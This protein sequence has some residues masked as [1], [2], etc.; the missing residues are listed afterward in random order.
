MAVEMHRASFQQCDVVVIIPLHNAA[1]WLDDCLE[2]VRQQNFSGS[3]Q[4]SIFDD[5]STDD[6]YDIAIHWKRLLD[7][8][9][10]DVLI[11]RSEKASPSGVGFS[12][13]R[14]IEQSYGEYLCFLDADD[15]MTP[16]RISKQYNVARH[17]PNAIVGSR[18]IRDPPGSTER[19]TNW[20]NNLISEQLYHQMYTSNGPTVIM[21]TWFCSRSV[22]DNVGGFAESGSGTPEDLIFF[23][24]HLSSGGQ[25][26]RVDDVLV[27]Y[28]Y[29]LTSVTFSISED[30][31]W[32]CRVGAI[33]DCV[34]NHWKQ[35]TIWNAGKQGKRFYRSLSETN[36]KK[37]QA[38]CDVDIRKIDKGV[39]VYENC[40]IRP[41]PTIPIVHFTNAKPPFIICVKLNLT[42]GQL[43]SN[44]ASLN[45]QEGT[46]YIHFN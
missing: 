5:S 40:K 34:I 18:F 38:F 15:V 44:L 6:S 26:I 20:A 12:K 27:T 24:R 8:C 9:G 7:A 11:G 10:I 46:D 4:V 17:N 45:L 23:Y 33:Q 42:G 2:S 3:I 19:Y 28:R 41:K 25:V 31:I 32:N 13:N 29:H 36:R 30:I 35:F 22:F 14:A 1:Q 21:P 16:L 37:V 39:Y 43:E